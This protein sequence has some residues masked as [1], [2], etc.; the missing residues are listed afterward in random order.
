MKK[1][2]SLDKPFLLVGTENGLTKIII[3]IIIT[4]IIVKILYNRRLS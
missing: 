2:T 4:I 1:D 3:I